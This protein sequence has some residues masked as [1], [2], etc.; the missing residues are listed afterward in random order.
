MALVIIAEG[1]RSWPDA[2][3]QSPCEG[4]C[5]PEDIHAWGRRL[6][7]EVHASNTYRGQLA[8]AGQWIGPAAQQLDA[9]I[10]T[11]QATAD[12]AA[13]TSFYDTPAGQASA[14]FQGGY[15]AV[16]GDLASEIAQGIELNNRARVMVWEHSQAQKPTPKPGPKPVECPPGYTPVLITQPG[17]TVV[18]VCQGPAPDPEPPP[19][20]PEPEPGGGGLV[21]L[22]VAA[23]VG[24]LVIYAKRG[25]ISSSVLRSFQK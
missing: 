12:E 5:G 8:P 9:E 14:L 21:L 11:W 1:G 15:S 25:T 6:R 24:A 16:I 2:P 17:G 20:Q 18:Q 3:G 7:A 4:S 23:G 19:P 13:D 10:Q 22:A